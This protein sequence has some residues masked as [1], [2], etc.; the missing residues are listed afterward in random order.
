MNAWVLNRT[1]NRVDDKVLGLQHLPARKRPLTANVLRRTVTHF[2]VKQPHQHK[3]RPAKPHL[4][5]S[6]TD[7]P[8]VQFEPFYPRIDRAVEIIRP[9]HLFDLEGKSIEPELRKVPSRKAVA[10]R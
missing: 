4:E 7:S 5:T 1:V 9:P 8:P 3:P 2:N 6:P 10:A